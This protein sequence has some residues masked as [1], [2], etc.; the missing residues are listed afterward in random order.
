[1]HYFYNQ[2]KI[3]KPCVHYIIP[4]WLK[5]NDDLKVLAVSE[6]LSPKSGAN[7]LGLCPVTFQ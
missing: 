7:C 4:T 5:Q 1:M 6:D 3:F 2:S